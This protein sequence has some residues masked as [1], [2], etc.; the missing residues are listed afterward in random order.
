MAITWDAVPDCV[1]DAVFWLESD[2]D[3]IVRERV[4][5]DVPSLAAYGWTGD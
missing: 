5:F 4:Y 3:L 2:D 1:V